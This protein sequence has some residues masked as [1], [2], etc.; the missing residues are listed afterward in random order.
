MDDKEKS[1]EGYN[2][3]TQFKIGAD[4]E[5]LGVL[6]PTANKNNVNPA[7]ANQMGEILDNLRA[8]KG[9]NYVGILLV[10]V[11]YFNLQGATIHLLGWKEERAEVL[12]DRTEEVL[13]WNFALMVDMTHSEISLEKRG[14]M[15]NDLMKD[16][17]ICIDAAHQV[18]GE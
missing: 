18:L 16:L 9:K 17:R 7:R 3:K 6:P 14:E 5:W 13:M 1:E 4:S 2:S 12:S 15:V 10:A 8:V 11:N